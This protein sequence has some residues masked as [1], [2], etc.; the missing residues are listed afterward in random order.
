V[1]ATGGRT[2]TE[3]VRLKLSVDDV[4]QLRSVA[5]REDRSMSSVIRRAVRYYLDHKRKGLV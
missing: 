4:A 5:D 2:L 3:V 1:N